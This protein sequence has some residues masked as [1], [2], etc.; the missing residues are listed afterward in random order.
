MAPSNI[1]RRKFLSA[2]TIMASGMTLGLP[3]FAKPVKKDTIRIGIIGTG[4][5]GAGLMHLIK[6]IPGMEITACCDIIPANLANGMKLADKG[7]K[8]Y[9]N[10]KQL[11]DDKAVDAV[12]IATP[13]FL[14]YP[15]AVDALVAGKHVYLEKSM[16]YTIQQSLDLVKKVRQSNLVFQL[17]FQYRYFGLY[18]RIKEIIDQ[19]WLGKITHFESQYNRNSDWRNPVS[20]P[21]MERTINW[22]MYREFCG[23]PLSELCAHQIDMINYLLGSHPLKAIGMGGINYWKD[24]RTTYDHIRTIYEYPNGIKSAVSSTLSN[25]YNGYNVKIFGDRVTVEI[26]RE[27]AFIYAESLDNARGMVDG[28]T[29][30]TLNV[31]TQGK[32]VKIDFLKPGEQLLEPTSYALIDFIQCIRD[33][34]RPASNED[35]GKDTSIAIHMGNIAADTET[36]QLWKPE[37]NL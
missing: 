23:G 12:I 29:G 20:D 36:I 1:S 15:M 25:A 14:H 7:A 4:N 9:T 2:G 35:T 5:R 13:L 33:K 37:Y 22:R 21:S 34:K 16:T 28:V 18:H 19:K 11:L 17:G 30:A 8:S 6:N 32:A 26:Q 10:Y 24:G 31:T 27:E 3:A